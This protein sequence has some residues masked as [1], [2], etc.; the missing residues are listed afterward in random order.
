MH[1]TK[2]ELICSGVGLSFL[3]SNMSPKNISII[4][5]PLITLK[6]ASKK[7]IHVPFLYFTDVRESNA[8]VSPGL[9]FKNAGSLLLQP[10]SPS[11]DSDY[12]LSDPT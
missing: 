3:F 12:Y 7:H 10:E 1:K 2:A 8:L 6:I 5:I 11:T 9:L 4:V